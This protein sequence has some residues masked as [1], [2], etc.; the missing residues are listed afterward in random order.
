MVLFLFHF[1]HFSFLVVVWGSIS[2]LDMLIHLLGA[3]S[4][5]NR[6]LFSTI[7]PQNKEVIKLLPRKPTFGSI[8]N[9]PSW[10]VGPG[11]GNFRTQLNSL[12]H[13]N[14]T[15]NVESNL[16]HPLVEYLGSQFF[17]F[18]KIFCICMCGSLSLSFFS[19]FHFSFLV[20]VWG[21]I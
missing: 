14:P 15:Q 21:S 19:F 16:S 13:K 7:F 8:S 1:F 9:Q 12:T 11:Q 18:N 17:A 5:L 10:T 3:S 6:G 4:S 20:V 2:F